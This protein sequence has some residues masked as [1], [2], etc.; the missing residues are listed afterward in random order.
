MSAEKRIGVRSLALIA[1]LWLAAMVPSATSAASEAEPPLFAPNAESF[2][3]DNGLQVVV[4]PDRRVPVVTHMLWYRAGAADEPPGVSGIAHFLEHLLFKGTE[5]HPDG[6]FSKIVAEIGGRENAFTAQDYTG[7]FQRVAKQ[8]LG[9]MMA[10]EADRMK[11]LVLLEEDVATERKVILEERRQRIENEPGGILSEAL[12]A[13]FYKSHPYGTP[14]IGW[15][16]EMEQLDREDALAFYQQFYAPEKAILVVAGD[17][18][19]EEVRDLA[20]STYGKIARVSDTFVRS[21]PKE[22]DHRT[23][24]RVV[25]SDERVRQPSLQQAYLVPS[26]AT[27]D[28]G[29]AEALDLLAEI[30]GGGTT[31]RFYQALV[32]DRKIA[33]SAGA[34]YQSTALDKTRFGVYGTP[35][36]GH[37]LE[38]LETAL[39]VEI[40]EIVENGVTEEEVTR[41]RNA[42]LADAIYAQDSQVTL[43]RVFGA[44]LTSGSTVKDVQ[45]WPRRIMSITPADIQAVARRYLTPETAA[46]GYLLPANAEDPS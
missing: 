32:V 15:E 12:T 43:A 34:W 19:A 27:A 26:Y 22:P 9:Q 11:N 2:V 8:H 33:A 23:E 6:E 36:E 7:Y 28:D 41:V 1:A 14:I 31:S 24:R 5:A 4:I 44:A 42:M 16:H 13:A 46:T 38:D 30:I 17:V 35:S 45:E 39:E 20:E 37:T 18:A 29:E 3:L 10:M 21:R 40:A 25:L